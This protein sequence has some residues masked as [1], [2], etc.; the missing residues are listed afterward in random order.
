V[1]ALII[2]S[3]AI[4]SLMVIIVGSMVP[5]AILI[6]ILDWPVK[7]LTLNISWQIPA[8]LLSAISLGVRPAIIASVAYITIGLFYLPIFHGGGSIGYLLTPDFGYLFGFVP[9]AIVCGTLA[10]RFKKNIFL[11]LTGS[12]MIGI[13]T[14]HITGILNLCIGTILTRW[15]YNFIDLVFSY[16]LMPLPTQLLICPAI[17]LL[18]IIIRKVLFIK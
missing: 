5:S 6:P 16:T 13:L 12:A 10:K 4:A 15:S 14:I 18:A 9:A 3:G 1:R 7:S 2:L 17:A 11:G 8:V